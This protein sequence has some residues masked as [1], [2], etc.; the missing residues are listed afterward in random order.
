MSLFQK[1]QK[2]L[3]KNFF[4]EIDLFEDCF[5]RKNHKKNGKFSGQLKNG[6]EFVFSNKK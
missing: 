3:Q 1:V 6:E 5:G 4:L 2:S